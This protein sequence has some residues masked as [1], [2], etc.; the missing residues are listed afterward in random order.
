MERP[1]ERLEFDMHDRSSSRFVFGC[2]LA[3]AVP[4]VAVGL[5]AQ[6]A[7]LGFPRAWANWDVITGFVVSGLVVLIARGR[8]SGQGSWPLAWLIYLLALVLTLG[9]AISFYFQASTFNTRFFANLRLTNLGAGLHAFPW[10]F[11]CAAAAVAVML[12]LAAWWLRLL[13]GTRSTQR[14]RHVYRWVTVLALA[15][16]ALLL[17]SPWQRL[18]S[19][20]LQYRH[21]DAFAGSATA[22]QLHGLVNPAP[23]SREQVLA[24]PGKNLV[25][26]YMES[27]ERIYTDDKIFKGLTPNLDRWRALGLDYTDYLTFAGADYTIAGLFSSQCGAPYLPSP[28]RALDL[29]GNDANA[30]SFQPSLV[31]LGDVLHAARYEQTFMNGVDLSFAN[32]GTFFRLHGFDHVWGTQQLESANGNRLAHP[33]WGLY[34]N[35]LFRLA[36]AKFKKLAASGRPFNLDVLTIDDHPPHGRPSPGCPKYAANDNDVLQAVHCTD[37]LVGRFLDTISR[38][39]AWKN[40]I[41]VVMSDHLSMRNDAWPLYP[42]GYERKP[43]LFVLNGGQ[44]R[45]TMRFYHMDIAPTVLH[46]MGVRTNATFL[47]GAD[48]SEPDAPGSLLVNDDA[49]VAIL[50]RALWS[51][52]QPL[53]LCKGGVLVGAADNGVR[54]GRNPVTMSWRGRRVVGLNSA[55]AWLV[56]I[57]SHSMHGAVL[58][59]G[60]DMDEIFRGGALDGT[61]LLARSAKPSFRSLMMLKRAPGE[62]ALVVTPLADADP[63]RQFS[64][65]WIGRSGGRTHLADVPRLRDLEIRSPSCAS[66]LGRMNALP[67]GDT[68]DLHRDFTATTAALYPELPSQALRFDSE[69]VLPYTR[70]FGWLRPETWGSFA[71][72]NAARLGFALPGQHCHAMD[73]AFKVHPFIHASRPALDVRVFANGALMA[74]WRF[75][76]RDVGQTWRDVTVPVRTPD[77]QCRVDLR[78]VFSRPGASPPP[79]PEDEDPRPLQLLFLEM[80]PAPAS[81]TLI[82][83]H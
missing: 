24:A 18:G 41:V 51:R 30:T 31:C 6:K 72:G 37:F 36:A 46:L 55:N 62:S 17:P 77:P 83:T 75:D 39:P 53:A 21:A 26:I 1:C 19:F 5:W 56:W 64:V 2:W 14:G 11:A 67:A 25:I 61:T 20:V 73:L 32:D 22:A 35:D 81:S 57:G 48:R 50:R 44:G 9:E 34:D 7:G 59:D 71:Q 68:L 60:V 70:D 42:K 80:Y 69:A 45:R 40:T 82:A 33:G 27:L 12:V 43:L 29:D 58:D 78:F 3:L 63:M 8:V 49:D 47:A 66:L 79:Y 38:N 54:I 74:T 76:K 28:V 10:L 52:A 15:I 23:V 16:V 13:P 4:L 65:D